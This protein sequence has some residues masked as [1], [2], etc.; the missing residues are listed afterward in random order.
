MTDLNRTCDVKEKL[1]KRAWEDEDFKRELMEN[2][3]AAIQKALEVVIPESINVKVVEETPDTMYVV[4]PVNPA[5]AGELCSDNVG[6]QPET[7]YE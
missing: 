4:L 5:V 2:P 6:I 1:I 3:K 7:W